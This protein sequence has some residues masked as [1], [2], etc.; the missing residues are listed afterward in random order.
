M[1]R[2]PDVLNFLKQTG[3][4]GL[5]QVADHLKVSKQG[6]L[7]HLEA[8][9]QQG[10]VEV[11]TGAHRGPGRP[12]H[13]YR[14]SGAAQRVFPSAHRE[15]A[16]ELVEFLDEGALE[17][18]F[19]SRSDRLESQY[20][21]R[22]AGLSLA[23]R[24]REVA[25]LATESGHMSQVTQADGKM[26]LRHCNCPIGDVAV[27]TGHACRHELGMYQRLFGAEVERKTWAAGGD[28]ACSYE[29]AVSPPSK[30]P[31]GPKEVNTVG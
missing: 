12:G 14:L 13:I 15:L 27:R 11:V 28:T 26:L 16:G 17:R 3:S 4:A 29:I 21:K 9:Q 18:F 22:L 31:R 5:A 6:A 23:E 30:A 7:R 24:V 8:L 2:K 10:L 25:R 1:D 20:G 19:A